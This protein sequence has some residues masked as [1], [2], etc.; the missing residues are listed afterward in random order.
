MLDYLGTFI[1]G[2]LVSSLFNTEQNSGNNY[3]NEENEYIPEFNTNKELAQFSPQIINDFSKN[4]DFCKEELNSQ[5]NNYISYL[6]EYIE[7]ILNIENEENLFSS[8]IDNSIEKLSKKMSELE[9]KHLN[10]L[11]VGPS[12]V[13]KSCLINSI[14]NLDEGKM[15]KTEVIKP[16][17]KAFNIYESEKRKNIRLID[18]RGI[19]KGDYNVDTFV[20]EITKYIENQELNGNPDNFIHCIWYCIT[21]TRFE[22]IEEK[23]LLKLSS[24]YDEFK[25][26][27][28][29]VYTQ[30]IV[31]IYYNAINKEIKKISKNFEFVPV[32][33]KEIQLSED[34]TIKSKNLD[35]LLQKS[36][37]KSKNAVHSSVF[38]ALR[39]IV[40][41]E[42]DLEI[43]SG[44]EKSEIVL[45][46][47]LSMKKDD[48]SNNK[49]IGEDNYFK[50]F[51]NILFEQ[52]SK[53]D[54]KEKSKEIIKEL[55][56]KLKEKNNEIIGKCLN[57]FANKNSQKYTNKLYDLQEQSN[58][59]KR[60]YKN[61]N[62]RTIENEVVSF[63][64]NS[65][66]DL[67]MNIGFSNYKNLIP[68][69]II[70]LISGKVKNELISLITG[71]S[72]KNNLNKKIKNQF[73]RILSSIKNFNF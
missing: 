50:I 22:D 8:R 33:A 4:I 61:M 23:T 44:V 32:V 10:I 19:E 62:R 58:E 6:N 54:L 43:K 65:L 26:P 24:I 72:T 67:A 21:G 53:K 70:K 3:E 36:I 17:T 31:P 18:S 29:V 5:Y 37:E 2:I 11:L 40:N 57:N 9:V 51:K 55:I 60:R 30:A 63:I 39:K 27:I 38:S 47:N 46:E 48:D 64:G 45:N 14:L 66:F 41:N 52:G 71:D 15:A 35:I 73:Q 69:K 49:Y 28:I 13:G 25:L 34:K 56:N 1:I 20:N 16:T 12:G 68:K 59:G 42:I 7:N